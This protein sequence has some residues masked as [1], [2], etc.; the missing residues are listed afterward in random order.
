MNT[1]PNMM[2]LL[3]ADQFNGLFEFFGACLTLLSVRR[4]LLDKLV[5]GVS[6]LPVIFFTAW[7]LWNL[8]YYPHLDQ[9]WSF[10]GGVFLVW[11]NAWWVSC[12]LYTSDA[13]DE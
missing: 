6:P 11:V 10:T 13:A 7:G 12:L 8:W 5:H 4:I 3:S 1:E 9:W 2:A